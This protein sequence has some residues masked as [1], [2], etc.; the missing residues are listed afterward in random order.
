MTSEI[1]SQYGT[2]IQLL[3]RRSRTE[4]WGL[5][6]G[7]R[8]VLSFGIATL[9]IVGGDYAE[10]SRRISNLPK[11]RRAAAEKRGLPRAWKSWV[12][13]EKNDEWATNSCVFS[14]WEEANAAGDELL[15]RWF[16]P[17]THEPRPSDKVVNYRFDFAA[18]KPER[19][20]GQAAMSSAKVEAAP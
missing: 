13:I 2:E 8:S 17:D 11:I 14:S 1:F 10:L 5:C 12:H 20:E 19:I 16:V 7:V 4:I 15:S 6:L 18:W 3:G 9:R